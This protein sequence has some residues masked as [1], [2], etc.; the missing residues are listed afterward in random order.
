ML[1][2]EG[3]SGSICVYILVGTIRAHAR[4]L[5]PAGADLIEAGDV[6]KIHAFPASQV[7]SQGKVHIFHCCATVPSTHFHDCSDP[8]HPSSAIEVEEAPRGKVC[9]LLTFAMV[10]QGNFLGLQ[11]HSSHT[12]MHVSQLATTAASLMVNTALRC[13]DY[14]RLNSTR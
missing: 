5:P 1:Y 8:P 9:I 10:V 12:E 14:F 4:S 11:Q 6:T 3:L 7:G 13:Q 2:V